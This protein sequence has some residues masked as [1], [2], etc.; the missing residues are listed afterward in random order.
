MSTPIEA[1]PSIQSQLLAILIPWVAQTAIQVALEASRPVAE[2][3]QDWATINGAGL[4]DALAFEAKLNATPD[5]P[6]APGNVATA[7]SPPK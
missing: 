6:A 7:V 2:V 3:L 4:A 1:T 5:I